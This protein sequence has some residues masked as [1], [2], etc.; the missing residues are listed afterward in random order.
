VKYNEEDEEE[1]N[2]EGNQPDSASINPF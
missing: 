2:G 1:E